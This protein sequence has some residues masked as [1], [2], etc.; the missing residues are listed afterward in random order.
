MR[1][2][3]I[4]TETFFEGE[5]QAVNLL[6]EH[7]LETLHLRKPFASQN[8]TL[9]F[10]RMIHKDYFAR[11]VLHDHY[12]LVKLM[13][14]KGFHL[15]RRNPEIKADYKSDDNLNVRDEDKNM[16]L[17]KQR[18]TLSRSCHSFEEMITSSDCDYVFLSPVFD[19]IS[20]IGYKQGFTHEQL[21]DAK[22]NKLI[23][24]RVIALGG[25]IVQNIPVAHRY[26]F[27][28]VAVLGSLWSDFAAHRK[29]FE[30]LNRFN[31]LKMACSKCKLM[32]CF[33][34]LKMASAANVKS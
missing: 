16:F 22:K 9:D 7:G 12:N 18:F 32:N 15:N 27:G 24:E 17:G 5:A 30:L 6:F 34:E 13:D 10:I 14:L 4:T 2:I 19:S 29:E 23:N 3:V 28:G 11:I 21:N 8:E 33:S 20:K 25:L 1:L 26:G 31:E